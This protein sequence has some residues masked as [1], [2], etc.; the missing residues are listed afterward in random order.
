VGAP[1][2]RIERHPGHVVPKVRGRPTQ[3]FD[4]VVLACHSDQAL[5]L[6]ADP[7]PAE[8]E[9]LG[10]IGWQDNDVVLHTDA[11]LLPR[12]RRAWA[13][14]NYHRD[15]DG[16]RDRV[17]V[18][19]NLT[20]LQSLPTRRQFLVTLNRGELVQPATVIHRET[21]AHPVYTAD[22][23]HARARHAEINGPNRTYYCGAY[24]GYGFHE[25]GVR[26]ALAV[27]DALRVHAAPALPPRPGVDVAASA[28]EQLY[29]SG[30]G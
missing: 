28:D 1:V 27:Y 24:W 3:Q 4:Q 8:R 29:L 9:V 19:Y 15:P 12:R 5:A 14:W 11:S 26:S 2:E 22:S 20:H 6:L 17:S 16:P 30:T 7:T 21:Y 25:D 13:S 10:A 18:T 23:L